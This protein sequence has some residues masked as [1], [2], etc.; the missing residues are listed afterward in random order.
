[1][2]RRSFAFLVFVLVAAGIV[3]YL[4]HSFTDTRNR[5]LRALNCGIVG[6]QVSGLELQLEAAM[7]FRDKDKS[8]AIRTYYAGVVTKRQAGLV[9]ARRDYKNIGGC[10]PLPETK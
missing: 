6:R 1:M 8:A 10:S 9:I 3:G 4:V 2:S 5:D 7:I